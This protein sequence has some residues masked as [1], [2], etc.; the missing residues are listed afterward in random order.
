MSKR[1]KIIRAMHITNESFAKRYSRVYLVVFSNLL[2][3]PPSC[4]NF[5]EQYSCLCSIV[6]SNSVV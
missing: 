6:C 1:L 2:T 4:G 5:I 3:E